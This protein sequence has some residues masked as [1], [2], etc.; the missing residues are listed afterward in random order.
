M[1]ASFC[2]DAANLLFFG[3]LG[4]EGALVAQ[5]IGGDGNVSFGEGVLT[6][7]AHVLLP[8]SILVVGVMS[9]TLGEVKRKLKVFRL[10]V[11]RVENS[12]LVYSNKSHG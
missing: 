2:T 8:A 7:A 11:N 4:T 5:T 9:H 1:T 3:L 10:V 12:T 6:S